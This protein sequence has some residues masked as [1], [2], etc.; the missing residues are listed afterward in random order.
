MRETARLPPFIELRRRESVADIDDLRQRLEL[1][2]S[3]L[4]ERRREQEVCVERFAALAANRSDHRA[5]QHHAHDSRIAKRTA[6]QLA[7]QHL[8]ERW[9][10][11]EHEILV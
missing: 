1:H 8:A 5:A 6:R 9:D 4:L 11:L 3:I 10:F 7:A 2:Q